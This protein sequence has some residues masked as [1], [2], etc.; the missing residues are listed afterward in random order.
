MTTDLVYFPRSRPSK[1]KIDEIVQ[2][3]YIIRHSPD[4]HL[5]TVY[6]FNNRSNGDPYFWCR[7]PIRYDNSLRRILYKLELL[8][9]VSNHPEIERIHTTSVLKYLAH[10]DKTLDRIWFEAMEADS[11]NVL[12]VDW[13]AP[14]LER[15]L[16]VEGN[17]QR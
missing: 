3:E 2:I 9:L 16:L 12:T 15:W 1:Q 17:V 10:V 13:R 7:M 11:G 4:P 8:K 5:I 14:T 6:G